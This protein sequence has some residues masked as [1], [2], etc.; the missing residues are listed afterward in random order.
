[1]EEFNID[2]AFHDLISEKDVLVVCGSRNEQ[3]YLIN[4][5]VETIQ[6]NRYLVTRKSQNE[7]IYKNKYVRFIV[8]VNPT[9]GLRLDKIYV[10]C[11]A[12][13]NADWL[14][15]LRT[16]LNFGGEKMW[17]LWDSEKP[18][19]GRKFVT[20]SN[21]GCTAYILYSGEDGYLCAE[22]AYISSGHGFE[23]SLWSY[24]P[25]D[26][27]IRFMEPTESDWY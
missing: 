6:S 17:K 13:E 25:D 10:T 16:R 1:M 22:D 15:T 8:F 2:Q 20:L 7:F 23:G 9:Y 14:N 21:D 4:Q 26:Y 12:Y 11:Y 24:I 5:F 18:E 19:L 27:P 3:V